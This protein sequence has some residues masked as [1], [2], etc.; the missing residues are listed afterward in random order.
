[1][2]APMKAILSRDIPVTRMAVFAEMAWMV[3]RPELGLVCRKAQELGHRLSVATIQS[4][5]P[6][7]SDAGAN[8]V[9]AWCTTLELCDKHGGLTKVGEDVAKTDEAPEPEQG[10]YGLWIARH[11]VLGVRLLAAERLS[12][13]K[14]QRVEEIRPISMLPDRGKVF[15]SVV[16]SKERFILRDFPTYHGQLVCIDGETKATCRLILMFDFD[17]ERDD[18]RLEGVIEVPQG[19]GKYVMQLMNHL[20]ETE[21]LDLWKLA[22][23][24][25]PRALHNIGQW[26]PAER[27]LAVNVDGLLENEMEQFQKTIPISQLEVPGKGTFDN[28]KLEDIPIGPLNSKD[29]QTWAMARFD[30]HVVKKPAYRSRAEVRAQFVTLTASTPLEKFSPTLPAHDELLRKHE[31]NLE[32]FWGFAAPVDLAPHVVGTEELAAMRVGAAGG[33]Q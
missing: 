8:N 1:M 20:P 25:G 11:E 26:N 16:E 5:L 28:V 6:G 32:T 31:K 4:A 12:S 9:I 33:V 10:V 21:G 22:E 27:R 30:R 3:R 7:L 17:E 19:G 23:F 2:E 24:W 29:A 14:E 18:W 15:R 13:R